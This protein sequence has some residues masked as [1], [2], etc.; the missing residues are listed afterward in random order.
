VRVSAPA[1]I[2]PAAVSQ[3]SADLLGAPARPATVLAA[4]P[5]ALYLKLDGP[6]D[7]PEVVLPLVGPRGLRLPTAVTVSTEVPT[8]GWGVQP[9]DVVVVGDGEITL[10]G[11]RVRAVRTWRPTAMPSAAGALQVGFLAAMVRQSPWLSPA[12]RLAEGV[13]AGAG[14]DAMAR[15][16][17][18]SGPGLTPSG[19]D[20]LCGVLLGIRLHRVHAEPLVAR[21]WAAVEPRRAT[22]TSLSAAL[23]GEA[24]QGYAVPAV[25]RLGEALVA[26]DRGAALQAARGVLGI[27]HT[28]G[29]DLLA[30]L[31]GC[32]QALEPATL[33]TS[34]SRRSQP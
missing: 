28:S 19:D 22:T 30:G 24:A 32:L 10:P 12:R 6:L 2:W 34:S 21:L 5:T 14:L 18:G 33:E 3:R 29:A 23:L 13:R 9:G 20:V 15:A 8:V 1:T 26:G 31:V 7:G 17:V 27:G 25:V 11:V 4:F 16:L